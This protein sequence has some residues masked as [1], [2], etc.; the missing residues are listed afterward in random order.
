MSSKFWYYI[1]YSWKRSTCVHTSYMFDSKVFTSFRQ[2]ILKSKKVIL[3][4]TTR[5]KSGI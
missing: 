2:P 3:T 4:M 5:F 1:G